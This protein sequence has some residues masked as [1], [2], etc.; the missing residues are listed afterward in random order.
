MHGFMVFLF[1]IAGGLTT[2][3]IVANLYWMAVRPSQNAKDGVAYWI[4]MAIAGPTVLIENST[5]SFIAKKAE[6]LVYA[7]ALGISLYW[8][9]VIGLFALTLYVVV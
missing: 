7:A 2:S 9:F 6:P 5:R 8:A 3:G 4:I 1:A